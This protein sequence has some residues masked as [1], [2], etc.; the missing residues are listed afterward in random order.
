MTDIMA[1][2]QKPKLLILNLYMVYPPNS[3][4]KVVIYNRLVEFSKYFQVSFC[5]F[6]ESEDDL[7]NA[8]KMEPYCDVILIEEPQTTPGFIKRCISQLGNPSVLDLQHLFYDWIESPSLEALLTSGKFDIVE[9]LSGCWYHRVLSKASGKLVLVPQN[10]ESEYYWG[11]VKALFRLCRFFALPR[12]VLDALLVSIQERRAISSSDAI[13]S[14]FPPRKNKLFEHRRPGVP[15]LINSGG[16]DREYYEEVKQGNR[17]LAYTRESQVNLTFIAAMFIESAIEGVGEFLRI[18]LPEIQKQ[19]PRVMM[20]VV[21]DHRGDRR[22]LAMAG[23]NS[24][25]IIH[26]LVDD[27]R[28]YL[29]SADLVVVPILHGSGIR[30]KILEALA[31]GK[32]VVTTR[33]GCQGLGLRDGEELVVADSIRGMT[34]KILCLLENPDE[35]T[36]LAENARRVTKEKFDRVALHREL[37]ASYSAL[38]NKPLIEPQ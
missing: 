29:E 7:E 24:A 27:T 4:A 35:I 15:L 8:K 13:A 31:S 22:V 36:R 23:E 21:G 20:H 2:A 6:R 19:Y 11:K 18:V 10:I 32:A 16:I 3:G 38:I 30:Y 5:C 14:I 26:G 1:M 25:A 9:L 17:S 37:A 33:K 34:S 12:A 28:D